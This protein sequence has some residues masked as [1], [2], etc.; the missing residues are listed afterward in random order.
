MSTLLLHKLMVIGGVSVKARKD[1]NIQVGKSIKQIREKSNLTQAEFAELIGMS[2]KNISA[3]ERG[4]VGV[5]L[6]A[7]KLICE[8]LNVS[9]D[10]I[11]FDNRPVNDVSLLAERLSFLSEEEISLATGFFNNLFITKA[12]QNNRK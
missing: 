2:T 3:I 10:R 1:V 8:K 5:S 6:A 12:K 11:L 7:L 4:R 9:S